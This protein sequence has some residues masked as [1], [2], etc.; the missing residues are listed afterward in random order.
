[1][2]DFARALAAPVPHN[3][4]EYDRTHDPAEGVQIRDVT[5]P[6]VLTSDPHAQGGGVPDAPTRP[7]REMVTLDIRPFGQTIV[8]YFVAGHVEIARRPSNT[9][10]FSQEAGSMEV[11]YQ[12][13]VTVRTPSCPWDTI[14]L[15]PTNGI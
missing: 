15:G 10:G 13:A 5:A 2:D 3:V 11:A 8:P 1:M 12:P 14:R 6:I 7:A 9:P 4:R